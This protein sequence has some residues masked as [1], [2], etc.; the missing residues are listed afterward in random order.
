MKR[1][2]EN[3]L[4]SWLKN[5]KRKPLLLKGARQVGKSYIIRNTFKPL[6]KNYIEINFERNPEIAICFNESLDPKEILKRLELNLK[7]SIPKE[8]CILFFDEAQRCP[9][10]I[11]SLRYFYE[12]MPGIP[13]IC[14]GSLID[15]ALENI[16]VPVGRVE[17]AYLHPLSFQEFLINTNNDKLI[18]A[19]RSEFPGPFSPTVHKL[20]LDALRVYSSCGG[21]PEVLSNYIEKNEILSSINF[22]KQL[23]DTYYDDLPKYALKSRELQN[24]G[25]ILKKIPYFACKSFKFVDLSNELKAIQIRHSL[26]LLKKAQLVSFICSTVNIPPSQFVKLDRYKILFLDIGLMQNA[27]RFDASRWLEESELLLNNGSIAE[28]FVGQQFLSIDTPNKPDLY[29]WER[30]EKSSSAEVDYILQIDSIGIPIEV[31]SVAAG[32]LNSLRLFLDTYKEVPFGV[33]FCALNSQMN[34][35]L[36]SLPH[37]ALFEFYSEIK[38]LGLREFTRKYDL[39]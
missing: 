23:L 35:K 17:Y 31:K 19:I 34:K 22:Q 33:R 12:D 25:E 32:R 2:I 29:Y 1:S 16:S 4:I 26:N 39:A 18:E 13:V 6:T 14:A 15:F 20:G 37:Y 9:Q 28:Q 38:S 21:M 3:F 36:L 8:D 10:A 5:P 24:V 27:I 30:I 11:A 7:I